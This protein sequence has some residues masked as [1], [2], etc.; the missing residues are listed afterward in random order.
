MLRTGVG[1]CDRPPES[2]ASSTPLAKLQCPPLAMRMC[3]CHDCILDLCRTLRIRTDAHVA[4]DGPQ[5]QQAP[6]QA[7]GEQSLEFSD[8]SPKRRL[9]RYY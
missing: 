8:D 6:Q 4:E 5:A 9:S 7:L 3:V 2:W 1:A